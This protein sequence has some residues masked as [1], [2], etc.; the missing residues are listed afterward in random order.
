MI[1]NAG[2]L[3]IHWYF[4]FNIYYT[5]F[6]TVKKFFL[7]RLLSPKRCVI[8]CLNL[9]WMLHRAYRFQLSYA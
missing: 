4:V 2:G 7:K 5:K 3:I 8:I 1:K 9:I 6:V